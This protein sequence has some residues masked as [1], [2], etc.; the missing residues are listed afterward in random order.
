[1]HASTTLADKVTTKIDQWNG[2][3]LAQEAMA[4]G[5]K[6]LTASEAAETLSHNVNF[7]LKFNKD[8]SGNPAT[9]E[10]VERMVQEMEIQTTRLNDQMK[11]VRALAPHV[12]K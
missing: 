2:P 1:M 6:I 3:P 5:A 9:R 4:A 11:V 8:T 12:L 10:L 7:I